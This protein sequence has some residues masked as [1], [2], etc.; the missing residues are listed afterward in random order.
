VA[1]LVEATSRK[2]AGLIPD[3]VIEI[4][5]DF[6]SASI[7]NEYQE[8]THLLCRQTWPV[9]WAGKLAT[10][11]CRMSKNPGS[12]KLLE[13]SDSAHARTGIAVLQKRALGQRRKSVEDADKSNTMELRRHP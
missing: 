7:K 10:C 12:L 2:M 5:T 3:Q 11:I 6:S 1:Q 8:Y 9:Y 13:L 4:F